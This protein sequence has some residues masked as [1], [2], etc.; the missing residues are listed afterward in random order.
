MISSG[1]KSLYDF[2][3]E[4]LNQNSLGVEF[5][6]NFMFKFWPQ[7]SGVNEF[8]ILYKSE[9]SEDLN[10]LTK[11]VVPLVDIQ[12]IE[13]PF[14]EKNKR[15]DFE[16]EFYVA[17][18]VE[19]DVNEFNQ[20]VIEFDENNI[21]Y[22]AIL[23]TLESIK[24]TLTYNFQ[25]FK[26][27]F[28]VKE[29]QKVNVFKYSGSY[30]QILALN[31][32][33]SRVQTGFYGNEMKFSLGEQ[34]ESLEE[35]DIVEVDIMSGKNTSVFNE[36][37]FQSTDQKTKINSRT[38]QAQLTINYRGTNVDNLVFNEMIALDTDLI[39]KPYDLRL[40]QAGEIYDYEVLITSVNG[41]FRNNSLQ[42]LTFQLEKV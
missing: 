6:G 42:T 14:V 18:R 12:T 10:F 5:S 16:K 15:S 33:A 1:N 22:Q 17:I 38:W 26:Y 21:K 23:E 40:E 13:I 25:G 41:N 3:L 7:G 34:G 39:F 31:F 11:E 35:L 24:E 9:E 28:K 29:P 30:Y 32:N 36:I 37:T 2:F 4:K 19:N 27:T 8:E 20:R